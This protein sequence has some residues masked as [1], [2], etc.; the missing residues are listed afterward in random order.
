MKKYIILIMLLLVFL[1][2]FALGQLRVSYDKQNVVA[3]RLIGKWDIDKKLNKHLG[4]YALGTVSFIK[5]SSVIPLLPAKFNTRLGKYRIYL[6][7]WMTMSK[8]KFPYLLI[9]L[10]GNPHIVYF[11]KRG[12]HPYGDGE[13]FNVMLARAKNKINDILF[14]GGDFNNQ[15][16]S[17]LKRLE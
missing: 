11:R 9:N 4:G 13:S 1:S 16:F 7:G 14:I 8:G 2:S 15:P 5:D 10:K 3:S 6:A 12:K 17:A